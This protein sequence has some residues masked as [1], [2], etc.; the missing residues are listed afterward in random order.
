MRAATIDLGANVGYLRAFG[1]PEVVTLDD[2]A[3]NAAGVELVEGFWQ[4]V[5]AIA[6][7]VTPDGTAVT[8]LPRVSFLADEATPF[9]QVVA[10]FGRPAGGASRFTFA[11]D[12]EQAGAAAAASIVAPLPRLLL[13]PGWSASVDVIGGVAGDAASSVRVARQRYRI[14]DLGE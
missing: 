4:E 2:F 5:L 7:L 9:C 13:L 10:P 8:R 6:L 1:P 12:V 3:G 14:V 11:V